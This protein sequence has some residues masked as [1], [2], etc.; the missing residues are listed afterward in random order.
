[1][2]QSRTDFGTYLVDPKG[3]T[4][5]YNNKDSTGTSNVTG[6]TLAVWPI[7]NAGTFIIPSSLN[8]TD[9]GTITRSDGQMQTTYKGFPLYYYANDK[10]SGDALGN[11]LGGLWYVISIANFPP[12]P[13]PTPTV[14]HSGY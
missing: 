8:A 1:M 4:L 12:T 2:L 6:N 9:F 7:L 11:G 13:S 3:M 14:T 10:A 5:Y